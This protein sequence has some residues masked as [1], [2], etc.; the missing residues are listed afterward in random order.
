VRYL[1]AFLSAL[2]LSS[3]ALA[4]PAERLADG[5]PGLSLGD[6]DGLPHRVHHRDGVLGTSFEMIIVGLDEKAQNAVVA[7]TL[8]EIQRLEKVLS[9]WQPDS[10]LSRVNSAASPVDVSVELAEVLGLCEEWRRRTGGAFSCRLG[11]LIRQWRAL[12]GTSDLPD[13]TALRKLARTLDRL[14]VAVRQNDFVRPAPLRWDVDGVAKGYVLDK[15]LGVA[16]RHAP[17]ASG[18][19]IDIGGDAI[20]FG[21]AAEGKPWRIA[22]ADPRGPRDNTGFLATLA[23][24]EDAGIA[25]SGHASRGVRVA[26]RHFSHV[27]DPL[28]GWPAQYAPAATVV[29]KDAATAD[30]LAT[31][32]SV[33]PIRKGLDLIERIPDAQALLVSES[34]KAFVSSGWYGLLAPEERH[35]P[36]WSPG[37][38]FVVDY[39]IPQRDATN[40]RRPYLAIWIAEKGSSAPL[41][42]LLLLGDSERWMQE[43]RTWWR[44]AGRQD[45]SAI[46]GIVRPTRRPGTYSVAWD[47]RDEHGHGLPAGEYL[48][49]IEAAREHGEREYLE[50]P[51]RVGRESFTLRHRGTR[52]VG[53]VEV[54]FAPASPAPDVA[55]AAKHR[56]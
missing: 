50:L 20:Y 47:G 6:R 53:R 4:A 42:Q 49:C 5:W 7:A 38:E 3:T 9:S 44:R 18:I 55:N 14:E 27:L 19:S 26:N 17:R 10:E 12:E 15:A 25:S 24:P 48:L 21:R 1:A 36:P 39:E 46:H 41:R 28:Q 23:L 56:P 2:W 40:Y 33:L 16:R 31:A 22:V 13:R 51:V 30:A 11:E 54:R 29:A 35:D 34:G 43:V 32:L 37:F 8:A 52:E 45:E